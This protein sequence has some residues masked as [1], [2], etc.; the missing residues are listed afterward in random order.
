M[1]TTIDVPWDGVTLTN[2]FTTPA[3]VGN[4]KNVGSVTLVLSA[5]VGD[6]WQN[7]YTGSGSYFGHLHPGE[8]Q[9]WFWPPDGAVEITVGPENSEGTGQLEYDLPIA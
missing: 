4:P 7:G 9:D 1:R 8:S 2:E 6:G 3:G 5:R